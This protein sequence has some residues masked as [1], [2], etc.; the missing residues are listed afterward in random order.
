MPSSGGAY[1]DRDRG[2]GE[3]GLAVDEEAIQHIICLPTAMQ[4][5]H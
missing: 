3:L 2:L 1:R 5:Q 4:G